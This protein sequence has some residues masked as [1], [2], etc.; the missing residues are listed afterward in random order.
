MRS[1]VLA[2]LLIVPSVCAADAPAELFTP[3][4]AYEFAW[5][6][7]KQLRKAGIDTRWI[8]WLSSY[9]ATSPAQLRSDYEQAAFVTNSLNMQGFKLCPPVSLYGGRL[10]RIDLKAL[11][12]STDAWEKLGEQGAGIAPFPEPYFHASIET[13][14]YWQRAVPGSLHYV[15]GQQQWAW[16]KFVKETKVILATGEHVA[17]HYAEEL[18]HLTGSQFPVY[19]TDWFCNYALQTPAYDRFQGNPKDFDDFLKLAGV[20]RKAFDRVAVLL[21]GAVL[22]S[23]VTYR[24]RIVE[25]IPTDRNYGAGYFYNTLDFFTSIRQNDIIANL[26][27]RK[28]DAGEMIWS[29]PNGLQGYGLVATDANGAEKQ[30]GLA[31]ANKAALDPRTKRQIKVVVSGMSCVHCHAKG[32]IPVAD[33]VRLSSTVEPGELAKIGVTDAKDQERVGDVYYGSDINKHFFRDQESYAAAV[34]AICGKD[35]AAVSVA[36]EDA[37][38]RYQDA[39]LGVDEVAIEMGYPKET[40]LA[41]IGE[42]SRVGGL[43]QSFVRLLNRRQARRDQFE[44]AF[45]QLQRLL[46]RVRPAQ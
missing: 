43:D 20:D 18:H 40:V 24:N 46:I 3:A 8:R 32:A 15:G 21:R 33:E 27:Q 10:L 30:I 38:F 29:L 44:L 35:S 13:P 9:N 4:S 34:K 6:D 17:P 41:L 22:R 7:A 1:I 39:P 11:Y 19:R 42:V 26:L 12:I 37:L 23:E 45:H 25:R 16:E 28:R 36:F 31:D 14:V 5:K 2:I